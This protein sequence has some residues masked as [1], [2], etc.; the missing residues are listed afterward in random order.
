MN[1]DEQG[2][3]NAET[4]RPG[5]V[6]REPRE[7]DK[8]RDINIDFYVAPF[9]GIDG[10][11]RTITLGL[12]SNRTLWIEWEELGLRV[13]DIRAMMRSYP[14]QVLLLDQENDRVF[15][16]A[17]AVTGIIAEPELQAA[18]VRHLEFLLKNYQCIRRH[19]SARNN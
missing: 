6:N 10:V 13:E 7:R 8:M 17:D 18:W 14:G 4:Q 2:F 19:E 5:E 16:N 12:G 15:L 9:T 11:K 3:F 1:T